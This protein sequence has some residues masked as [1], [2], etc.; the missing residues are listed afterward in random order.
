MASMHFE[1]VYADAY[2][3]P[4]IDLD[5]RMNQT[6]YPA[7]SL[8]HIRPPLPSPSGLLRSAQSGVTHHAGSSARRL[9]SLCVDIKEPVMDG[10]IYFET[11]H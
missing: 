8:A 10:T 7:D 3:D 11:F 2:F 1:H 5:D 4:V 6:L 9:T